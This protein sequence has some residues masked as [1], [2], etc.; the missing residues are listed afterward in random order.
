MRRD[1]RQAQLRISLLAALQHPG[2]D[3]ARHRQVTPQEQVGFLQQQERMAV[4]LPLVE[5]LGLCG[6]PEAGHPQA[7]LREVREHPA[8]EEH[9]R[10]PQQLSAGPQMEAIQRLRRRRHR[11]FEPARLD[12]RPEGLPDLSDVDAIQGVPPGD[13]RLPPLL[14]LRPGQELAARIQAAA[15]WRSCSRSARRAYR[16]RCRGRPN[17]WWSPA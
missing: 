17:G 2:L 14:V 5:E 12:R 15:S 10:R 4:E 1:L 8:T 16:R 13:F 11:G 3:A 7:A 6:A 9:D